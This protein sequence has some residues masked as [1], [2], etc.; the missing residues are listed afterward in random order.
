LEIEPI[1][2]KILYTIPNFDTAGSGKA[3]LNIAS[4]LDKEKFEPHI[5]C[6]HDKGEFFK[7]VKASKIP[8]HIFNYMAPMNSRFQ[9]LKSCFKIARKFREIA[10]QII[11]SFN[12]SSDYSEALSAKIARIPWIYTKKNMSW[13]GTSK[14]AWKFRTFLAS[15]IIVQNK[16]MIKQFFTNKKNITLVYRGVNINEF[17]N[18]DSDNQIS[19][20]LKIP[21]K[22]KVIL[23]VANLVPVKGI[24]VIIQAFKNLTLTNKQIVLIIVGDDKNEYAT[25]LKNLVRKNNLCDMIIFA[26]K[27]FDLNRIYNVADI[28]VSSTHLIGRAEGCPVVLLE[29]MSTGLPVIASNIPGSR[30]VLENFKS[31]LFEPGDYKELSRKIKTHLFLDKSKMSK[32]GLNMRDYIKKNFDIKYEVNKTEN[33]YK[34]VLF[35]L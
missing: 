20:E 17:K 3:L 30:D 12:Y 25:K 31:F 33:V 35:K 10:P 23:T 29:A 7:V 32:L 14:N 34:Q 1:K 11:H 24:E 26:G 19:K 5:A 27:R 2:I 8:V 21:K 4:R 28:F 16:D 13:G 22:K 6:L 9:G 15:H 18:D